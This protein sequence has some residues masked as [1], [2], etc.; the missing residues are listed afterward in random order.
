MA[1]RPRMHFLLHSE[2]GVRLHRGMKRYTP[3]AAYT[4]VVLAFALIAVWLAL[5]LQKERQRLIDA[6]TTTSQ[7]QGKLVGKGLSI[8]H[9]TANHLLNDVLGRTYPDD[10]IVPAPNPLIWARYS[11]LL[12]ER[13]RDTP[14]L[15]SLALYNE[16]CVFMASDTPEPTL[17]A[18]TLQ[19]CDAARKQAGSSKLQV[20]YIT[21]AYALLGKPV[22]AFYRNTPTLDNSFAGGAT[23]TLD[24]AHLQSW[25]HEYMLD[26]NESL[27]IF[28]ED[29]Q[30]L[31][32]AAGTA[33]P[34]SA[35]SVQQNLRQNM[36]LPFYQQAGQEPRTVQQG[37]LLM[38]VTMADDFPGY[39]VV[40]FGTSGLLKDWRAHAWQLSMFLLMLFAVSL[41]CTSA[42]LKLLD[43]RE[44]LEKLATTD[45]LTG[46][47]NRRSFT[48]RGQAETERA[49]RYARPLSLMM[50][51]ADHFKKIN[52]RW[53]HGTG[54]S[55]LIGLS[56]ILQ[57]SVRQ[58]DLVARM[59][60][61]EFAILLPE[62]PPEQALSIAERLKDTVFSTVMTTCEQHDIRVTVS[63][64][65]AT[66]QEGETL[67]DLLA[68]ADQACYAS[69]TGGRNQ[70]NTAPL[71]MALAC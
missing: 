38:S 39:V 70:V 3:I 4:L 49:H 66:L 36:A 50:V 43:E 7:Q 9:T 27:T 22:L 10:F 25:L 2:A 44:K 31:A 1:L 57:R 55:V 32:H 18:R 71:T 12:A 59:G 41:F 47:L 5:D 29:G 42:Y 14:F 65:V 13:V 61:E 54:D 24:I 56:K 45:A 63:V 64:G 62:T 53:G 30:L 8:F 15:H 26:D 69:K 6:T 60:G 37:G 40:S 58:T 21:S 33:N 35:L 17:K 23:T 48:E 67:D 20:R 46:A 16:N 34:L 51:D 28:L 11:G 19:Q 52:D 68:R